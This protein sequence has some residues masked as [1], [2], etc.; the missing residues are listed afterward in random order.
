M[1]K[2]HFVVNTGVPIN[3]IIVIEMW[4]PRYWRFIEMVSCYA[5][6]VILV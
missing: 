2:K 4:V 1:Q 3:K 6:K 5:T